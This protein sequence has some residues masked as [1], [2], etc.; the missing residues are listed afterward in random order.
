MAELFAGAEEQLR[1]ASGSKTALIA[2]GARVAVDVVWAGCAVGVLAWFALSLTHAG[3]VAAIW[4]ANAVIVARLVRAPPR[5][6]LAYLLA[7][8]VGN[9]CGDMLSGDALLAATVLSF[10]NTIEITA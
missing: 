7:G 8:L 3:R 10:C 2:R 9:V 1:Q 6:W 4:P 5:H